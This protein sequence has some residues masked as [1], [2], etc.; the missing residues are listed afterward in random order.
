MPNETGDKIATY[1]KGH[2]PL[3]G[4]VLF[5]NSKHGSPEAA[6]MILNNAKQ[7]SIPSIVKKAH[8]KSD[9]I[10]RFGDN[11]YMRA[12]PEVKRDNIPG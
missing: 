7:D 5:T 1:V 6:I 8:F 9:Y 3:N 2:P 11:S 12:N 10:I 4:R